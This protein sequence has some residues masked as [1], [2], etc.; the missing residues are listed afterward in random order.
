MIVCTS[1]NNAIEVIS[2]IKVI[3]KQDL[4]KNTCL[5]IVE[6]SDASR[7]IEL[8]DDFV[9]KSNLLNV[10]IARPCQNLGYLNGLFF[11]V[12]YFEENIQIN[13]PKWI[14]LCNTDIDFG[15]ADFFN[16][17]SENKYDMDVWCL[18]PC[19]YTTKTKSYQNPHY[20]NRLSLKKL[21]RV[22]FITKYHILFNVYQI[23]SNLKAKTKKKNIQ[24]SQF[25]YA[26]HGSIFI[27]NRDFFT[28]IEKLEYGAFLYSEEMFIAETIK[29]QGKRVYYDESLLVF[30]S[31]NATTSLLGNKKRAMLI[32]ESLIYFKNKFY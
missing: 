18:A 16:K 2:F 14:T 4:F 24:N 15:S 7:Q 17:V 8:L 13:L 6:N 23:L 19:I 25:V 22:I 20:V 5:V 27:L 32:H 1:Y 28:T 11:G 10:F 30:H 31:E 3:E 26:A 21:N 12:T 9:S 29:S